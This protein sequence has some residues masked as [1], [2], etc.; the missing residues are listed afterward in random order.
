MPTATALG[1]TLLGG[2]LG[3]VWS[4]QQHGAFAVV[5]G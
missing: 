1:S 3:E 4:Y 5:A 2:P